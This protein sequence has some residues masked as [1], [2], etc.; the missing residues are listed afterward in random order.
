MSNARR[1]I[2]VIEEADPEQA[3]REAFKRN[4]PEADASSDA[5]MA[6]ADETRA[7]A[8]Q[9][10]TPFSTDG[11]RGIDS[12]SYLT[13]SSLG[14]ALRQARLKRK[15]GLD[16]VAEVLHI[17]K[18]YLQAIEQGNYRVLPGPT[19]AVGFVRA[20]AGH[21]GLDT[22]KAI[23][24]YK[25]E[26]S[27]QDP[28]TELTF[29]K[30]TPDTRRPGAAVLI[31]A[32]IVAVV[33]FGAWYMFSGGEAPEAETATQAPTATEAQPAES[34]T[35]E[36]AKPA[37]PKQS[38]APAAPTQSV[39]APTEAPVPAPTPRPTAAPA[40]DPAPTV[41]EPVPVQEPD[42]AA[43]AAPEEEAAVAEDTTSE[44][45]AVEDGAVP[46]QAATVPT[47]RVQ[48]TVVSD[49][50]V[51]IRNAEGAVIFTKLLRPGDIYE[52]PADQF[53]LTLLTGNVGALRIRVD[54]NELPPL[55]ESGEVRRDISLDADSLLAGA[56]ASE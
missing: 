46:E 3:G 50:W 19:Y 12:E 8:P 43:A 10:A 31:G 27:D 54:G 39:A 51:Q 11:L 29:P 1:E 52:P 24:R 41:A 23:Q 30:P 15:F 20:Y 33:L 5:F 37:A 48:V 53:G 26:A 14:V 56:G 45:T 38:A 6:G 9:I 40:A 21:L 34:P 28:R 22:A 55:G 44:Q 13:G 36:P 42:T 18:E 49:S 35:T 2:R 16:D 25:A 32:I 17:R 7:D 4:R 47:A